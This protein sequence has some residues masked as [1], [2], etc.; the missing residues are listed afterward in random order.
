M[1][2]REEKNERGC[3]Y[4]GYWIMFYKLYVTLYLLIFFLLVPIINVCT[5]FVDS[6]KLEDVENRIF[7]IW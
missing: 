2:E 5:I 7:L 3:V 6:G 1:H 4:C